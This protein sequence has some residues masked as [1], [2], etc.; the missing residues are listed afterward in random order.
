MAIV[1]RPVGDTRSSDREVRQPAAYDHG[2]SLL[3]NAMNLFR[4]RG[5]KDRHVGEAAEPL[6]AEAVTVEAQPPAARREVKREARPNPNKP[7]WGSTID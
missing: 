2:M 1:R 5:G 4:G 3:R 6:Q 7:G